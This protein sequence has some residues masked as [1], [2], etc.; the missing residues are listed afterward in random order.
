MIDVSQ[1]SPTERTIVITC[2]RCR[3][4]TYRVRQTL[5]QSG[6]LRPEDRV[7][8][9]DD[10]RWSP[11]L[12]RVLSANGWHSTVTLPSRQEVAVLADGSRALVTR[13][14]E[15][16]AI[17]WVCSGTC[18]NSIVKSEAIDR[19]SG[20]LTPEQ[21]QAQAEAA[22]VEKAHPLASTHTTRRRCLA[23]ESE[24]ILPAG[25]DARKQAEFL[26]ALGWTPDGFCSAR[27]SLLA[28]RS[29]A[30]QAAPPSQTRAQ[31]D[32]AALAHADR[33]R[34]AY[35]LPIPDRAPP[36]PARKSARA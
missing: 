25:A 16:R 10:P 27:C 30:R 21:A 14:P 6:S 28:G 4:A 2:P 13:P 20:R 11:A 5:Q 31:S 19:A 22:Y 9:V 15:I 3:E 8:V 12:A 33:L 26:L 1:T 35:S 17:P 36:A 7:H 24:V 23:C 32:A 34:A 18:A 29:T